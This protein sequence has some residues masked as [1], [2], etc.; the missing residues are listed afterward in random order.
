VACASKTYLIFILLIATLGNSTI[1]QASEIP[2]YTNVFKKTLKNILQCF[3]RPILRTPS[4]NECFGVLG[5][6]ALCGV[7]VWSYKHWHA[8]KSLQ[9]MLPQIIPLHDQAR[10]YFLNQEPHVA[11]KR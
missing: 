8:R 6:I 3:P 1:S 2:C 11:I 10:T 7:G 4:R 9:V 5:G